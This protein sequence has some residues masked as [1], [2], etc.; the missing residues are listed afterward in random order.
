[1]T[2]PRWVKMEKDSYRIARGGATQMIMEFTNVYNRS[3][4]LNKIKPRGSEF[5]I[6]HKPIDGTEYDPGK[7]D[8]IP[9]QI[10]C[11]KYLG[12]YLGINSTDLKDHKVILELHFT[13]K[14][15]R[16]PFVEVIETKVDVSSVADTPLV[17]TSL[18]GLITGFFTSYLIASINGL[19]HTPPIPITI[20]LSDPGSILTL[21]VL[22]ILTVLGVL[23]N[24]KKKT[25]L[26][27]E[28]NWGGILV[29]FLIG[30]SGIEAA[31][32]LLNLP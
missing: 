8:K 20:P 1:M 4:V 19:K 7:E 26:V 10:K 12:L 32:K 13:K 25:T 29:G 30:F 2:T 23:T 28:D 31:K 24:N 22:I 17:I 9:F 18:L 27:I 6:K 3:I 14:G 11:G 5:T 15:V 16:T 21:I